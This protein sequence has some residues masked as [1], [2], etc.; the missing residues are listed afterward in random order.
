MIFW[1]FAGVLTFGVVLLLLWPVLSA[2]PDADDEEAGS[3][4]LAVYRDQLQELERDLDAGRL[5]AEDF[6][7]AKLEVERRMLAAAAEQEKAE[8]AS[9]QSVRKRRLA[10]SVLVIFAVPAGALLTYVSVGNPSM[11]DLPLAARTDG[12]GTR[13]L[14]GSPGN[15]AST[16]GSAGA[17][18]Q[19]QPGVS[20]MVSGLEAKL[21]N[22]PDDG[23]G[24]ALLGRSYMVTER[25]DDAVEAYGKALALVP[26]NLQLVAARGEALVLAADGMV[27]PAAV[28]DFRAVNLSQPLEPR[29][30][31]YL[32]LAR[33]QAADAAGALKWWIALEADTPPGAPWEAL[34][35]QRID[36]IGTEA[37]IDVASLRDAERKSRPERPQQMATPMPNAPPAGTTPGPTADDVAAAQNMTAEDRSAMIQSM[38]DGLASRLEEEPDDLDGWL[39]LARA[40][41]VLGKTEEAKKA[42]ANAARLAPDDLDIQLSYARALF[43]P[44]TPEAGMTD[45]FISLVAHI[46]T[47]APGN[48]DG[49]FY[50]GLIAYRKGDAAAAKKLWGD[51]LAMMGPDAPARG[52]L[53]ARIKALGG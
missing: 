42:Q 29:A 1:V 15:P 33:S 45:E 20:E 28:E 14:A 2:E 16:Q 46:R 5:G 41:G 7:A 24:W 31:Y 49:L 11:P 40:Y 17:P 19:A 10:A 52:M 6:E 47:L 35:T 50:G 32:G 8:T 34:V 43:P 18:Q 22:N 21:A 23:D 27:P 12:A 37:G 53:E 9:P 44:G 30:R 26:D 25:Y 4:A 38:V 39:R 13:A 48:P 51:L 3:E 36:E